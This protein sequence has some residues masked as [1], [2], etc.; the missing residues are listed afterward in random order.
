[1]E[2]TDLAPKVVVVR[3]EKEN[4]V[5]ARLESA[6]PTLPA[7]RVRGRCLPSP[8]CTTPRAHTRSPGEKQ[9]PQPGRPN[10]LAVL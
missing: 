5:K 7:S 6:F 9:E 1:M 3:S 10:S 8:G 2:T 4:A